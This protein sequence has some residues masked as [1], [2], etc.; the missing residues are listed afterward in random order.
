[1]TIKENFELFAAIVGVVATVPVYLGWFARLLSW[2]RQRKLEKLEKEKELLSRLKSSDREFL[3]WLLHSLLLVVTVF[4]VALMFRGA[5]VDSNGI[6]L[7]ATLHWLL[8]GAAYFFAVSA[9]GTYHR[10]KNFD[11]SIQKI[12]DQINK[13]GR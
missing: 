3:G 5:E 10:L 13:L 11:S 2:N 7:V 9:L 8:G 4:C 1:M 12:D 6:K